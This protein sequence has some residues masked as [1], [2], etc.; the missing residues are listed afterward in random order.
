MSFKIGFTAE[1]N[2]NTITPEN[3]F[4]VLHEVATPRKSVVKVHF[5]KRNM[6]LAYYN[7]KFDLHFGDIVFVDGKLEGI[8]QD[9]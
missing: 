3:T 4:S 1:T 2:E 6:T 9:R 8:K 5:A 7:D